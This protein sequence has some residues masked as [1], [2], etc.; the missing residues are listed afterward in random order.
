MGD[1]AH[2]LHNLEIFS[3]VRERDLQEMAY[4]MKLLPLPSREL[5]FEKDDPIQYIYLILSGS[6][7][8]QECTAAG[9]VKI[10]N[11]LGRGEFLGITMASLPLPKYP[12]T[13]RCQEDCVLVQIP[14]DFFNHTLLNIPRVK[15]E[16]TRQITDR[17][18][19]FQNDL[20]KS[21]C[22]VSNRMADFLLRM[23]EKQPRASQKRIQMP[24][25]R[26]DIS[27]KI[28][29]KSETVIRIL[30]EWTKKGWLKTDEKH[31]EVIDKKALE[32]VRN[33]RP[34]K[35]TSR[36]ASNHTSHA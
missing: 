22:L 17:F 10:F 8:I 5:V 16:V 6:V 28:G 23:L 27:L 35:K 31:I 29:A 14:L 21:S 34:T 36:R 20:C 18:L 15:S 24:L 12:A 3:S 25:T 26:F 1:L 13:V 19:E 9:D 33:D 2:K 7:K 4:Y 11:F 32:E 30:S